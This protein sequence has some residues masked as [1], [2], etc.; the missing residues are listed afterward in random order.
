MP[1]SVDVSVIAALD[2]VFVQ[3]FQ[4]LIVHGCAVDRRIVQEHD[5]FQ[6]GI[7]CR[8]N[9]NTQ[10]LNFSR[11]NL[12]ICRLSPAYSP[13]HG[14]RKCRN[15]RKHSDCYGE[16]AW[17][18]IRAPRKNLPSSF[19]RSTSNHGFLSAGSF[20]RGV[21]AQRQSLPQT[22]P[23]SCPRKNPLPVQRYPPGRSV[24]ASFVPAGSDSPS[25]HRKYPWAYPVRQTKGAGR[26]W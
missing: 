14:Y 8:L 3:H 17:C 22:A 11:Q 6:T 7:H 12:G 1:F 26:L 9:G 23:R 19:S 4:N 20:V 13:S 16:C 5:R 18:Q 21:S 15:S 10:P 24:P 25:S 2:L